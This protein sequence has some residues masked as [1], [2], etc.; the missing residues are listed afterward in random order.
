MIEFKNINWHSISLIRWKFTWISLKDNELNKLN[1]M[2]RIQLKFK[3]KIRRA[4]GN[5]RFLIQLRSVPPRREYQ[6]KKSHLLPSDLLSFWTFWTEFKC[7][8]LLIVFLRKFLCFCWPSMERFQ[9]K[10]NKQLTFDCFVRKLWCFPDPSP[11]HSP[12]SLLPPPTSHTHIFCFF[13]Q[14]KFFFNKKKTLNCVLWFLVS[15]KKLT[16]GVS[17]ACFRFYFCLSGSFFLF[18]FF[19]RWRGVF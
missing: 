14:Q 8:L 11:F 4:T 2:K 16:S 19:W 13:L 12:S 5:F 17:K 15:Q 1:N 10:K 6:P 7:N 3:N 18:F 9:K